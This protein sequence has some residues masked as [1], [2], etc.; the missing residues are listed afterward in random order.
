MHIGPT[1]KIFF[2]YIYNNI[3]K[4]KWHAFLTWKMHPFNN[5]VTWDFSSDS[6][7]YVP[8]NIK[9]ILSLQW[10]FALIQNKFVHF[11]LIS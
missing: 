4:R 3:C 5:K 10:H 7:K 1:A 6:R 2:F 9:S 11:V 8:Y